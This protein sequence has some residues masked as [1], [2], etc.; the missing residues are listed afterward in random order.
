MIVSVRLQFALVYLKDL[1]VFSKLTM[2]H[3]KLVRCVERLLYDAGAILKF[4]KC[5]FFAEEIDYT[6]HVIWPNLLNL[7]EHVT[8]KTV[9][10]ENPTTQIKLR[11]FRISVICSVG[12]YQKLR[13]TCPFQ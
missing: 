8:D 12:L 3:I 10:L 6:G 2:Y 1:V 4:K 13:A 11:F 7:T 9:E 5:R